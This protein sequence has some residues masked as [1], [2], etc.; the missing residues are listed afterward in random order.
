MDAR[1]LGWIGRRLKT[2]TNRRQWPWTPHVTQRSLT[3]ASGLVRA[4]PQAAPLSR[5]YQ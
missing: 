5:P 3:D 1:Y 4:A 2:M